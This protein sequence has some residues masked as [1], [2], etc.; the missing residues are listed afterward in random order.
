M[1]Y[2][3]IFDL[4][5]R[6]LVRKSLTKV[7]FTKNFEL[8]SLEKKLLS[9]RISKM[10]ILT[11]LNVQNS[12]MSVVKTKDYNYEDILIIICSLKDNV[13]EKYGEACIEMIQR[14]IPRQ[15]I[16]IV[17]DDNEYIIN[18]CDKRIN[19]NNKSK[20][21][22]ENYFSTKSINKL[23]KQDRT[24][25]L[26]NALAYKNIDKT[27]IETAYKSY[28]QAII[29]YKA[30]CLTGN[31]SKARNRR[32][33][34]DIKLLSEVENLEREIVSFRNQIKKETQIADRVEL[35]INIQEKK[36][37]IEEIKARFV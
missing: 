21:V 12:N 27:N 25:A 26:F 4:P 24:E 7:F 32:T 18:A 3:N 13:L 28:L 10:E 17:E 36:K 23:Y 20:V 6:L 19:Q 22:I 16:L 2:S 11:Q 34:Q 5:E 33:E 14:H 31:Y 1:D 30:A 29:N 35:N 9:E 37:L 15:I 8:Y